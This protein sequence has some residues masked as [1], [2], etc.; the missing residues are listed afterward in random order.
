MKA[1][2]F[3]QYVKK[4]RKNKGMTIRQLEL[5]SGVSNSYLSLLENGK[6]GIPSPEVLKKISVPLDHSYH[7]LMAKAG[8]LKDYD[9]INEYLEEAPEDIKHLFSNPD[10]LVN[11]DKML[12]DVFI[13]FIDLL[14]VT[15]DFMV[16]LLE[17]DG[18]GI[19]LT[20]Q[21]RKNAEKITPEMIFDRLDLKTKLDM[22]KHFQFTIEDDNK[23]NAIPVLDKSH[24]KVSE[25]RSLYQTGQDLEV[26][27]I[28][29]AKQIKSLPPDKRQVIID[30]INVYAKQ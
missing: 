4:L 8:Y 21:Q 12:K 19:Q 13:L 25:R 24:Q 28:E 11:L 20:E 3:G 23:I 27:F 1:I 14:G 16:D 9:T 26:E 5:Y 29:L 2:E 18:D 6:R 22:L 17:K 30:L 7:D 15:P 10:I